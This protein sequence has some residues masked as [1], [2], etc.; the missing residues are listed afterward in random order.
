[1][2]TDL[3]QLHE[4]GQDAR[5]VHARA[6][7]VGLGHWFGVALLDRHAEGA[8]VV[9][10]LEPLVHLH[11]LGKGLGDLLFPSTEDERAYALTQALGGTLTPLLVR[12]WRC[13]Y[14]G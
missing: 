2:V 12:V 9:G 6:G 11:L 10:E 13:H 1:M 4:D 8:L 5:V 7:L 3:L 14:D